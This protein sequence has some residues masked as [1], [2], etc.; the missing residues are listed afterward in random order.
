MITVT[1]ADKDDAHTMALEALE[2]G[3]EAEWLNIEHEVDEVE[4]E[5]NGDGT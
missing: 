1:A 2:T 3:E 4:L 5:T